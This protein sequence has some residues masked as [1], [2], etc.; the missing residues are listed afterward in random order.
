M[1][2]KVQASMMKQ[3]FNVKVGPTKGHFLQTKKVWLSMWI[4]YSDSSF[5]FTLYTHFYMTMYFSIFQESTEQQELYLV[6]LLF[7]LLSEF[8]VFFFTIV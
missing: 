1:D 5:L 4:F 8:V 3:Y 7:L 2:V 6:K